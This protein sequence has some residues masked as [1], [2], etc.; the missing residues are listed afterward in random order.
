MDKKSGGTEQT[1]TVSQSTTVNVSNVIESPELSP[2]QNVQI[3][4]DIASKLDQAEAAKRAAAKDTINNV[5][6]AN[7][8]A[9]AF[10]NPKTLMI[11][12]AA[13]LF[14]IFVAKKL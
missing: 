8:P 13:A 7:I 5:S 12:G 14:L 1:Q 2:L 6:I 11:A 3:L 10:L 9:A 4:A